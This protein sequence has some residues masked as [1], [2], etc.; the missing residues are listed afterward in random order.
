MS[1]SL[2]RACATPFGGA[3]L[4][5]WCWKGPGLRRGITMTET[6]AVTTT[7]DQLVDAYRGLKLPGW[8]FCSRWKLQTLADRLKAA[9]WEPPQAPVIEEEPPQAPVV[10]EESPEA[11][12]TAAPQSRPELDEWEVSNALWNLIPEGDRAPLNAGLALVPD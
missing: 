10:E 3:G 6:T 8:Q 2:G 9:G 5:P 12:T 7:L 11:T 4:G 1:Y